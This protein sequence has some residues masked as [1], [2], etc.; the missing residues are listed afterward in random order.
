MAPAVIASASVDGRFTVRD[1]LSLPVVQFALCLLGALLTRAFVFGDPVQHV[2]ENWYLFVGERLNE[3]DRLYRDIWDRKPPGL[4]LLYRLFAAFPNPVL[5]YQLAAC[6]S[7]AASATLVWR[8]AHHFTTGA[9]AMVAAMLYLTLLV[10]LGGAGG[11]SPVFYN[12]PMAAAA[13]I[14]G[15]RPAIDPDGRP[16]SL[17]VVAMVLAGT[18]LMVKPTAAFEAMALGCWLAWSMWQT[19]LRRQ[20]W[21]AQVAKLTLAGA[22]PALIVF[23][24][25]AVSGGLGDFWQATV[26]SSFAKEAQIADPLRWQRAQLMLAVIAFPLGATILAFALNRE[27]RFVAKR[28]FLLLWV[29]AASAG[30]FSVPNFYGHYLLPL[31]VPLSVVASGFIGRSVAL[32]AIGALGALAPLVEARPWDTSRTAAHRVQYAELA[33]A[34]LHHGAAPRMLVYD[35][36]PSLYA[37]AGTKP[38]SRLSFPAHLWDRS[39]RNVG[40]VQTGKEMARI[41]SLQPEIVVMGRETS[42]IATNLETRAALE[43]YVAHCRRIATARLVGWI[44]VER[45]DVYGDCAAP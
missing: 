5:V 25:F 4:F 7:A 40:P 10:Q 38:L 35:G 15:F 45:L 42:E 12:L 18:A 17:A 44:P 30:L 28:N 8:M 23:G 27:P 3:G 16:R 33:S 1:W 9:A 26:L 34:V 31:A 6:L 19:G 39:E 21:L 20:M 2:D 29:A 22:T 41:I 37:A 32:T 11:Q 43:A 36:P 13:L 24:C 14:V